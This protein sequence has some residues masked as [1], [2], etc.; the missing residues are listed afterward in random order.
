[1][2]LN[3]IWEKVGESY[4]CNRVIDKDA[5]IFE[6]TLDMTKHYEVHRDERYVHYRVTRYPRLDILA[7]ENF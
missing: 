5:V 3:P 1:M 7:E 6:K 4:S 2:Y